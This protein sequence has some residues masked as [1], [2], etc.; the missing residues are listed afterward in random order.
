MLVKHRP[1]GF[2]AGNK[3]SVFA[4]LFQYVAG[5]S[6][7]AATALLGGLAA[8]ALAGA[9]LSSRGGRGYGGRGRGRGYGRRKANTLLIVIIIIYNNNISFIYWVKGCFKMF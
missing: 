6:A 4:I 8:G 1:A 7:L 9:L 2:A 5:G 3:L